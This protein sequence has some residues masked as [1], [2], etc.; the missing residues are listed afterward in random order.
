MTPPRATEGGG[1]GLDAVSVDPLIALWLERIGPGDLGPYRLEVEGDVLHLCSPQPDEGRLSVDLMRGSSGYRGAR[2]RNERLVRACGVSEN[3]MV[4]D[5]TGGLGM[6]AWLLARAG[7]SVR[8][9]E[10]H[11]VVAILLADGLRRARTVDSEAVDRITLECVDSRSALLNLKQADA[12][13]YLDPMYP[14]RRKAALGDRR[15]RLLAALFAATARTGDDL[16]GLLA[17]ALATPATRIVLKR[18]Q[19][20]ALP[21]DIPKPT[22]CLAGRSTRF[23][24]WS[25][26]AH[27]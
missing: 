2:A 6:D 9:L 21:E 14:P 7:A 20:V 18:P 25:R 12:V 27:Q 22:Y 16:A 11:P 24:V 10:Q 15:L 8:V 3:T 1:R 26:P 23:D 19:R 17:A 5:A 4:V 13:V